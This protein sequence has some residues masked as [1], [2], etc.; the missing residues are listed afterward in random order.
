MKI[1]KILIVILILFFC[2]SVASARYTGA[3]ID[4]FGPDFTVTTLDGNTF[5]M[6]NMKEKKPVMMVFW[7][8]WCKNCKG[9][10]PLIKKIYEQYKPNELAILAVN[11]GKNETLDKI[12]LFVKDNLLPYPVTYDESGMVAGKYLIQG[13]PTIILVDKK[14]IIRNR[15][16]GTPYDL[17]KDIKKMVA[18]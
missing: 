16:R 8:T 15:L 13:V 4:D 2:H 9:Q 10:I 11:I 1:K 14:G 6:S 7:A 5:T 12:K 3:F 18:E 17:E